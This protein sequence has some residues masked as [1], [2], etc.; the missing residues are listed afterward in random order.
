MYTDGTSKSYLDTE[1]NG[2]QRMG[3]KGYEEEVEI[4]P[5]KKAAKIHDLCL[6]ITFDEFN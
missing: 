5:Q 2:L 4:A 6:G 3:M 1:D